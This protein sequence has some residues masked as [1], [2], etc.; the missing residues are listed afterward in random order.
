MRKGVKPKSN[1][2]ETKMR[3]LRRADSIITL[4]AMIAFLILI[5]VW[6]K[7]KGL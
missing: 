5:I 7:S 3:E 6:A 1:D 4:L 2:N